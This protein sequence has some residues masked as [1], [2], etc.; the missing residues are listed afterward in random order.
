MRLTTVG[1]LPD[2][3]HSATCSTD[4]NHNHSGGAKQNANY[5]TDNGK[6]GR[7]GNIINGTGSTDTAGTHSRTVSIDS[8]DR[9]LKKK[10]DNL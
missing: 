1:E 3:G 2:H 5:K 6:V 4:G 9:K 7:G 10:D 8:A